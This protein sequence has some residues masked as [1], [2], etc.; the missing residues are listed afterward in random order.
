MAG[1]SRDDADAAYVLAWIRRHD[2]QEFGKR[3]AQQQGKRRFPRADDIDPALESLAQRGYIRIVQP[4]EYKSGRPPAPRYEVNPAL[5][6]LKS[7][8]QNS[9]KNK[10][11]G[12][13]RIL[14][15]LFR[16]KRNSFENIQNTCIKGIL[17]H[18]FLTLLLFFH[19]PWKSTLNILKTP[20]RWKNSPCFPLENPCLT[21]AG[22]PRNL[23][24]PDYLNPTLHRRLVLTFK[25][26]RV[27][28]LGQENVVYRRAAWN[29][30]GRMQ[31]D[32]VTHGEQYS[33][34]CPFCSDTRQRLSINYSWAVKD[35]ETGNDNLHL[36]YCFNEGCF[37]SREKQKDL[38]RIVF[39]KGV[40]ARELGKIVLPKPTAVKPPPRPPATLP[41]HQTLKSLP[42]EHPARRYLRERNFDAQELV[43]LWDVAYCEENRSTVRPNFWQPRLLIPIY[44]YG[45]KSGKILA[46][47]QAREIEENKSAPKYLTSSG[48][49]RNELLYGLPEARE[50]TGPIV[51]VEG[52]TDVWR[53]GPGAVALFGKSISEK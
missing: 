29:Q 42:R 3:E 46:G 13:L 31:S 43:E 52:V 47:W 44:R 48:M 9:L 12:V 15:A 24:M 10:R 39:P 53:A 50:T 41:P 19:S 21:D 8:S 5:S 37:S 33:V 34:S 40:H 17:E 30:K 51:V 11:N 36:C 45:L 32:V 14:R 1:A 16:R 27:T 2:K 4:Q 28:K 18:L 35:E 26:V 49:R 23:K 7:R 25:M 38:H 20:F 22:N 6:K